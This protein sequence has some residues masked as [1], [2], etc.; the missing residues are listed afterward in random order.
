MSENIDRDGTQEGYDLAL[1]AACISDV[2]IPITVLGGAGERAHVA[3]L[4][5]THGLL[6]ASAGSLFVF[7]GKYRAVLINYPN[8][9]EKASLIAEAGKHQ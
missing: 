8:T 6:G 5:R 4:W 2:T 3:D 7:K 9:A 1:V